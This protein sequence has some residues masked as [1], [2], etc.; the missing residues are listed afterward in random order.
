AALDAPVFSHSSAALI[1]GLP[2]WGLQLRKVAVCADGPTARSRTT[3]LTTFRTVPDLADDVMTV[4]GLRVTTPA[5]TV[6]DIARTAGRDARVTVADAA[7]SGG[8]IAADALHRSLA[9]AAGG[10]G[11]GRARHGRKPVTGKSEGV[12]GPRG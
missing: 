7:V 4:N 3:D 1:H 5:R 10:R 2:D 9:R 8:I 12:R 6:T 11:L